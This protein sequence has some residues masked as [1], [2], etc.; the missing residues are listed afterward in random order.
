MK[1]RAPSDID[2]YIDAFPENV[3]KI[4]HKVRKTIQKAAPDAVEAISYAIPTFRLNG[5]LVHFAA[6]QNHIG[7]YP[8]PR[9]VAEFKNDMARYEGGKGTARFPLNEPIPY[10][11]IARI[12][13]FRVGKNIEKG[14]AKSTKRSAA[15]KK[16]TGAKKAGKSA[17]RK[18]TA[19][20][21]KR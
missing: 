6:F 3:Q 20:A 19:S 4:L 21:K 15:T 2:E 1:S 14:G 11:L 16:R 5:N 12:V 8:A 18:R 7:L 9:G 17:A 13:T 10:E